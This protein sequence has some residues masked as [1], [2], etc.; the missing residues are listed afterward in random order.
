MPYYI[1]KITPG[2]T[3]LTKTLEKVA[4]FEQ[5]KE[6][7]KEAKTMR[8]SMNPGDPH[9]FKVIFADSMLEAEERLLERREAPILREWEK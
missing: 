8:A 9:N 4:E 3:E 2:A 5:F 6:A 7:T 1:Y